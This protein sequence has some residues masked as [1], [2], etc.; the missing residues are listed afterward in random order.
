LVAA[1]PWLPLRIK[2]EL[3]QSELFGHVRGAFSGALEN[4]KGLFHQ[5]NRG[6]LFLDEIGDLSPELQA[7][8]LLP[9]EERIVRRVGS[10][11]PEQ[12]DLR[13]VSATDKDLVEAM[14]EGE[15]REQ[16]Y[17]RLRECEV[18]LPSLA[19]RKED[20]PLIVEHYL[21]DHNTRMEEQKAFAPATIEYLQECSW[22]GNVR[23]LL[24]TIRV[25]LQTTVSA[26][27]EVADVHRMMVA[28]MT[29]RMAQQSQAAAAGSGFEFSSDR[30]LKDDI[31]IVD[32]LKIESTLGTCKGNVSKAA[33]MLGISRETLHNKIRR[34]GINTHEYRSR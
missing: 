16:L 9:I 2:R 31:A 28:P 14:K 24:S 15:F 32:K 23:E 3:F 29:Q 30:S 25:V 19:D 5:A 4:K 33:A 22:K 1:E 27:I 13:F 18:H 20:I 6:T 21:Q 34:Y 26:Y 8:L 11:E 12:V 7:N 17:H 10:V